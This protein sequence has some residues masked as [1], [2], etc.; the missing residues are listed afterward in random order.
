M[1]TETR[2]NGLFVVGGLRG[3][4]EGQNFKNVD[5][6]FQ[7]LM[8]LLYKFTGLVEEIPR[9][10]VDVFYSEVLLSMTKDEVSEG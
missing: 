1:K 9:T 6:I 3:M 7:S 2:L 8:G 10:E 5:M 4:L